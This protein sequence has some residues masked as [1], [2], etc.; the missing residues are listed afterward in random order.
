M[1]KI[2]KSVQGY[3]AKLIGEDRAKDFVALLKDC[4]NGKVL[5]HKV[6]W[7]YGAAVSFVLSVLFVFPMTVTGGRL[8][9]SLALLVI[10]PYVVWVLKSIWASVENIEN[11]EFKGIPKVYLSLAA[12]VAAVLGG[13]NFFLALFG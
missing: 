8:G 6:F 5:L 3:S 10:S 13:L 12:K 2:W 4:W 7:I 11:D 9:Q 1:T